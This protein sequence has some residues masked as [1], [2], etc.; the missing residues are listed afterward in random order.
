[1]ETII[2]YLQ[3]NPK[4]ILPLVA[5]IIFLLVIVVLILT[6]VFGKIVDIAIGPFKFSTSDNKKICPHG[7]DCKKIE[8]A[9]DF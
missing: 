8:N 3:A 4:A 9:I 7:E 1:M 5:V 6:S 2:N